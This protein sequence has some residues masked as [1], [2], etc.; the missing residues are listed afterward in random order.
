[1][2]YCLFY[3]DR[4]IVSPS[5]QVDV[6]PTP[7]NRIETSVSDGDSII[8]LES[9]EDYLLEFK[10]N[11]LYIHNIAS[12][13][14]GSF[15][16]E[17]AVKFLGIAGPNAVVKTPHGI[18]W[19]N[20]R[21]AYLFDGN[22]AEIKYLSYYDA[23]D[24]ASQRI[25]ESTWITYGAD[26]DGFMCGYDPSSDTIVMKKSS[27]ASTTSGIVMT[28]SFKN[29]TFSKSSSSA[30]QGYF[31]DNKVTTNFSNNTDGDLLL[32]WDGSAGTTEGEAGGNPR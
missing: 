13:E 21:G 32:G 28:Y 17:R 31:V 10:T 5:N 26:S 19:V 2:P 12:G 8:Q 15:F 1:M 16:L 22:P 20:L 23:D 6:F 18:F 7:F 14:P 9:Y 29:N 11:H 4:I 27:E 25:L 30:L 3:N 24:G